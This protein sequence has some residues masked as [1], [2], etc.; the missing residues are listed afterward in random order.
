MEEVRSIEEAS[1]GEVVTAPAKAGGGSASCVT[2]TKREPKQSH[3]SFRWTPPTRKK[4]FARVSRAHPEVVLARTVRVS[5]ASHSPMPGKII[6]VCRMYS[7]AGKP[8]G[9]T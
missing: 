5:V 8:F 4:G 2:A 1:T 7:P 9:N 3:A 6:R